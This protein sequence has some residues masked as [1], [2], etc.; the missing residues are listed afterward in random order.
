MNR[1]TRAR[2][3]RVA[4]GGHSS[5]ARAYA[6]LDARSVRFVGDEEREE[7]QAEH[8]REAGEKRHADAFAR[9]ELGAC[10]DDDLAHTP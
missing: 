10:G 5:A 8:E 7:R 2:Y 9:V 1:R 3:P 6:A 4:R